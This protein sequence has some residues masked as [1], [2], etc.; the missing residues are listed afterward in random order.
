MNKQAIIAVAVVSAGLAGVIGF[1]AGLFLTRPSREKTDMEITSIKADAL[2]KLHAADKTH[3]ELEAKNISLANENARQ[4]SLINEEESLIRQ[5]NTKLSENERLLVDLQKEKKV[6][7]EKAKKPTKASEQE[8]LPPPITVK[9]SGPFNIGDSIVFPYSKYSPL[10]VRIIDNRS[11]IAEMIKRQQEE[12]YQKGYV[13]PA[14]PP[15]P[16]VVFQNI[17]TNGL[18]S[19]APLNLKGTYKVTGTTEALGQTVFVLEPV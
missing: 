17:D 2:E 3:K 6:W 12:Q 18:V 16:I 15:G 11:L 8:S 4:A 1:Q 7:Q 5:L 9:Q 14:Y 19:D 10:V 13:L